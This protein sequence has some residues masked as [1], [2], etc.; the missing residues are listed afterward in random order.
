MW[1]SFLSFT[2]SQQIGIIVLIVIIA[3]LFVADFT[4][5]TWFHPHVKIE[6]DSAF[7]HQVKQ[8]E[9]GLQE[10][11]ASYANT[12]P[13]I[14]NKHSPKAFSRSSLFDF[15]PNVIDSSGLV[16]L[17]LYPNVA[18]RVI[19]YRRK[20]GYFNSADEFGKIYGIDSDIIHRLKPY[21]HIEKRNEIEA[22]DS[23]NKI[24]KNIKTTA[25]NIFIELNSAD[26]TQ[27]QQLKGIGR[28]RARQIIY[29]RKQ[30]GGF[31][32]PEQIL[33]IK[34]FPPEVLEQNLHFLTVD[35][36]SIHPI[37][38]NRSSVDWLKKHPYINFYQAKA[39]YELRRGQGQLKNIDDLKSLKEFTPE[40]LEK[41]RPYLNFKEFTYKHK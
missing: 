37:Y 26:T 22:K 33:E 7:I 31:Y 20:G 41:L 30:L 2:R 10:K 39:I 8:F 32:T 24:R 14:K 15:D 27:L 5:K 16:K 1:K 28:Y 36:D 29:Y 34:N 13:K 17:G 6:N 35:T 4:L 12:S 38:V 25:K 19:H 18:A 11:S 9:D 21:I 3:L 40:Q 23:S